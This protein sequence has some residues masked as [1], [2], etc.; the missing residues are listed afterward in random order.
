M[1]YFRIADYSPR[2][3]FGPITVWIMLESCAGTKRPIVPLS[4]SLLEDVELGSYGFSPINRCTFSGLKNCSAETIPPRAIAY[5]RVS[6]DFPRR[7]AR[8]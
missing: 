4:K 5:C 1:D 8:I 7:A 6:S 3:S 2:T